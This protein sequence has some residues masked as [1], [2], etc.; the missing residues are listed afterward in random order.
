[1]NNQ[2]A[3][4]TSQLLDIAKDLQQKIVTGL[5]EDG[6]EIKCLPTYIH[7]K[8]DGIKGEATVFDLGGT[9]FRAAIV[10]IDE[11]PE[12]TGLEEKAVSYTHLRAHETRHD[13]VCRLLL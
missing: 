4:T 3:L 5:Q 11:K 12:I 10:S 7:P 9:N 6:T 13:L 1:M 8:K 2:F